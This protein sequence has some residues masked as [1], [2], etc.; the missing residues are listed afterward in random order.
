[1]R[2]DQRWG[3]VLAAVVH[4]VQGG[5]LC[6]T[7][8]LTIP[9]QSKRDH[10][11]TNQPPFGASQVPSGPKGGGK[12]ERQSGAISGVI[13]EEQDDAGA[14]QPESAGVGPTATPRNLQDRSRRLLFRLMLLSSTF[15]WDAGLLSPWTEVGGRG[16]S[17]GTSEHS[18]SLLKSLSEGFSSGSRGRGQTPVLGLGNITI[19]GSAALLSEEELA[20]QVLLSAVL[21][22]L[23]PRLRR[24]LVAA[25]PRYDP[26]SPHSVPSPKSVS[27]ITDLVAVPCSAHERSVMARALSRIIRSVRHPFIG[28]LVSARDR[29]I[30]PY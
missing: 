17:A 15:L 14:G 8:P 12:G 23:L 5:G 16:R 11:A 10:L 24:A 7:F 4:P 22:V 29:D 25:Q 27:P 9:F 18:A 30:C 20:I 28:D 19:S 21:P 26:A 1:M 3:E 6:H 13:I 2:I